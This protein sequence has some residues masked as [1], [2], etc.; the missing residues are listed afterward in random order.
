METGPL[1][2]V[3]VPVF[4]DADTVAAAIDSVLGQAF[5]DAFETIVVNDGSTDDT[6]AVLHKFAD[7]IRVLT[8]A[9][10]GLAAAR[11][12]GA[13][14]ARGKYLAFLDADDE[15]LPHKL[16]FTVPSLDDEPHA[17]LAYSDVITVDDTGC[18]LGQSLI[19]PALAHA[20]SRTDLFKR[21][22]P[23]IP[24]TVVVRSS[25]FRRCGGFCEEFR[26][27]A[28]HEDVDFWLRV[29][30][31]GDFLFIGHKLARYRVNPA[32]ASMVRYEGNY[33]LFKRRVSARYGADA[34]PLLRFMQEGFAAALGYQGLLALRTG[35][36]RGARLA[37]RR[38]LGYRPWHLRTMLRLLRTYVP[39][40]LATRLSGAG[41]RQIGKPAPVNR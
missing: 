34:A 11:N 30:E 36:R 17:V 18:V 24:S 4:N 5:D 28:G 9:N 23:I 25:A 19:E 7:K 10:R 1:V 35:D 40:P 16:A 22:W 8:Q 33:S 26:G 39:P 15:W 27:A 38:A 6:A 3:I 2:S 29:R 13:A 37:F 14:L 21:W 31:L 32:A 12:A 20:P 41:S